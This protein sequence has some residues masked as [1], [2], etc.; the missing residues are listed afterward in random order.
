MLDTPHVVT[1]VGYVSM[2]VDAAPSGNKEQCMDIATL[3][4]LISLIDSLTKLVVT[5][6]KSRK[7]SE[8]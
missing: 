6:V 8:K 4:K 3:I 1:Y 2:K 5:I 7:K